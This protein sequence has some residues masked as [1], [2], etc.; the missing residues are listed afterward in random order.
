MAE[1]IPNQV[2]KATEQRTYR[3]IVA[4]TTMGFYGE[5]DTSSTDFLTLVAQTNGMLYP[6]DGVSVAAYERGTGFLVDWI[7]LR[8]PNDDAVASEAVVMTQALRKEAGLEGLEVSAGRMCLLGL[9]ELQPPNDAWND[10]IMTDISGYVRDR[11]QTFQLPE[12]ITVEN[13]LD[14]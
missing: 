5:V 13:F 2:P 1:Q 7:V 12:V 10:P 14:S 6:H 9:G 11:A 3:I 8:T 4:L